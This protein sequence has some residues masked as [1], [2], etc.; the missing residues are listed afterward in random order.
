MLSFESIFACFLVAA[1]SILSF[2]MP[3]SIALVIPPR[4][5]ISSI[6]FHDFLIRLSVNDS[7]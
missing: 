6:C 7:K 4:L 2:G 5:S 3:F 1:C